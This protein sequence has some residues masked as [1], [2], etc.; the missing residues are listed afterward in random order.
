MICF[1]FREEIAEIFFDERWCITH[2]LSDRYYQR[3]CYVLDRTELSSIEI[4]VNFDTLFTFFLLFIYCR[5]EYYLEANMKVEAL[6]DCNAVLE[7]DNRCIHAYALRSKLSPGIID[8]EEQDNCKEKEEEEDEEIEGEVL[9]NE[10]SVTVKKAD[11]LA[12]AAKDALAAFLV[13]GSTDLMFASAAEEASRE[14]CRISA[15]RIFA[16]RGK[17]KE[18]A[19]RVSR[20]F[21]IDVSET[22]I[23]HREQTVQDTPGEVVIEVVPKIEVE[24]DILP[25]AW[26][27]QSF[28]AGYEPLR[29]VFG[30]EAAESDEEEFEEDI[31]KEGVHLKETVS[32]LYINI[33]EEEAKQRQD[34]AN[35]PS[36]TN[37]FSC[38]TENRCEVEAIMVEGE[39]K[40]GDI[41]EGTTNRSASISSTH[42]PCPP[43]HLLESTSS[44]SSSSSCRP[45]DPLGYWTLRCLVCKL[46]NIQYPNEE[47]LAVVQASEERKI[48]EGYVEELGSWMG[49]AEKMWQKLCAEEEEEGKELDQGA[50]VAHMIGATD[51]INLDEKGRT[52]MSSTCDFEEIIEEREINEKQADEE[53]WDM[54]K[55]L[56]LSNGEDSDRSIGY[57]LGLKMGGR[58]SVQSK[59][60]KSVLSDLSSRKTLIPVLSSSYTPVDVQPS[61]SLLELEN[62]IQEF[63]DFLIHENYQT[64]E[65]ASDNVTKSE[66]EG[67]LNQEVTKSLS[68]VLPLHATPCSAFK[69]CLEL[70][71]LPEIALLSGVTFSNKGTVLNIAPSRELSA[72]EVRSLE[73]REIEEKEKQNAADKKENI[74]KEMRDKYDFR[75]QQSPW[76]NKA[77]AGEEEEEEDG[78]WEDCDDAE[79][80]EEEEE[81]EEGILDGCD[82][83]KKKEQEVVDGK[84]ESEISGNMN[85]LTRKV[86]AVTFDSK[87]EVKVHFPSTSVPVPVEV[88]HSHDGEHPV[89]TPTL[90]TPISLSSDVSLSSPPIQV[91]PSPPS[92]SSSSHKI[93]VTQFDTVVPTNGAQSLSSFQTDAATPVRDDSVAAAPL[94]VSPPSSASPL[95]RSLHARLLSICSSIAYLSGDAIGAVR[96]LRASVQEDR[97]A[98]KSGR[99]KIPHGPERHSPSLHFY[100]SPTY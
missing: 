41:D 27:V 32:L 30:M 62:K 52:V 31:K 46:E 23:S 65:I 86:S 5:A 8:E 60:P 72:W 85:D 37:K 96:C 7:M 51:E 63:S 25:R 22:D 56:N 89:P 49:E 12:A 73:I 71:L 1:S 42:L 24:D 47:E 3:S 64:R 43:V 70:L 98:G 11:R 77:A 67:F 81:E 55:K 82:N 59:L 90:I 76:E 33:I 97:I 58:G 84:M 57:S 75:R 48:A 79:E 92:S 17:L 14:A 2:Q 39:E 13:G 66:T 35:L 69:W 100:I 16:E 93:L 19:E 45:L 15:K 44:S 4:S 40:D 74:D 95:S 68:S 9:Q 94:K 26:L 6:A 54:M 78:E 18:E 91:I 99:R 87:L 28:F 53:Y 20:S 34:N 29:T 80:E 50:D 83:E 21:H 10:S 36:E 88:P 38:S 61:E